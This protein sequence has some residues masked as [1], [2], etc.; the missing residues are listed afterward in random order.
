METGHC[1]GTLCRRSGGYCRKKYT[2]DGQK[3]HARFVA[4]VKSRACSSKRLNSIH[5]SF[6]SANLR[7]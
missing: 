1:S 2:Y 3:K 4:A 7:A 5:S 6:V